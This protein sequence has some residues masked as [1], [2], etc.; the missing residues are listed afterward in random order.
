MTGPTSPGQSAGQ[1]IVNAVEL[2]KHFTLRHGAGMVRAVDGVS[3]DISRGETLALV[4]ESGCGKSTLARMVAKLIEPTSGALAYSGTDVSRRSRRKMRPLRP[5]V[6]MVF[7]DPY[8]SLDPRMTVREIVAEPLRIQRRYGS[9]SRA[10]IGDLLERVG[11]NPDYGERRPTALSGG[12]RQRLCIARALA[13]RPQLLVLDEPVSSLDASIQAQ[14]LNLFKDLQDDLG[15][16]YLFIAHDLAVVRHLA[17]RVA[18]MYLGKV[19][20]AG[21]AVDVFERPTHPYTQALLSAVPVEHPDQRPHASHRLFVGEPAD[22]ANP[23]SGC[24]YRTRCYRVQP[25][26][27]QEEPAPVPQQRQVA[28]CFYAAPVALQS[29]RNPE[30]S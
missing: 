22:P 17:H 20:E 14:V 27:A 9:D 10:H 15:L 12:Q 16:A 25:R 28:A 24:H 30:E 13:L 2:T 5:S 21:P 29:I 18:V 4:G 7:Q 26:C 23:P 8:S 3:F 1:P 6:Q 19:V 11:L